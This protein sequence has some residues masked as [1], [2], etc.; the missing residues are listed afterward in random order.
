MAGAPEDCVSVCIAPNGSF[1]YIDP[2]EE[3]KKE[4]EMEERSA[5]RQRLAREEREMATPLAQLSR[6]GLAATV[7]AGVESPS[8][9]VEGLA[10][11]ERLPEAGSSFDCPLL[12]D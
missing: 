5:K 4:A 1:E 9:G 2:E 8:N 7:L 10:S 11:P 12:L 6:Q 3:K